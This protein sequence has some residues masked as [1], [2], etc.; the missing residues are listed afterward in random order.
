MESVGT[1]ASV[2]IAYRLDKEQ[3][4]TTIVFDGT[5]TA[6]EWRAH[7]QA[8]FDDPD[9]P[10]GPRNLTDLRS[11][12]GIRAILERS[13][14]DVLDLEPSIARSRVLIAAAVAATRLL[15]TVD[16]EQRIA[17]LEAAYTSAHPADDRAR[18]ARH[19]DLDLPEFDE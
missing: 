9:W 17:R 4:L 19:G 15:E 1:L 8:T 10:P 16:H 6:D 14:V 12:E 7:L 3:G 18:L 13:V 11:A 2:G 5:I